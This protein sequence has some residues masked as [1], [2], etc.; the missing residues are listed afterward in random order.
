MPSYDQRPAEPSYNERPAGMRSHWPVETPQWYESRFGRG[1][2]IIFWIS[3]VT[4]ISLIVNAGMASTDL[5]VWRRL[6]QLLVGFGGS[7]LAILVYQALVVKAFGYGRR[8]RGEM[9][10]RIITPQTNPAGYRAMLI[11]GLVISLR[12]STRT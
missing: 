10:L 2:K 1:Y 3:F 11:L 4:V 9:Q 5:V 12:R 6:G 7:L 8:S